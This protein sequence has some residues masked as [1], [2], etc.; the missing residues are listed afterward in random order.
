MFYIFLYII[1]LIKLIREY[2]ISFR[3]KRLLTWFIS[4]P[5]ISAL[6]ILFSIF[7]LLYF[8]TY[9]LNNYKCKFKPKKHKLSLLS[10]LFRYS[11]N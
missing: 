6:Y 2:I 4:T 11:N 9:F 10:R 8:N 5:R 7:L 1:Y 3:Y